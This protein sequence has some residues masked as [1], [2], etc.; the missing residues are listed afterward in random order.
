MPLQGRA[1]DGIHGR[2]DLEFVAK[3]VYNQ[4][5]EFEEPDRGLEESGTYSRQEEEVSS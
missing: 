5:P 4:G 2:H 1:E 3:P